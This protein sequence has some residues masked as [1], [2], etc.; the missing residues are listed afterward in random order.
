MHP[1]LD[2]LWLIVFAATV[3]GSA[4][5]GSRIVLA[6]HHWREDRLATA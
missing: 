1:A 2:V 4:V 5:S 3:V 6:L